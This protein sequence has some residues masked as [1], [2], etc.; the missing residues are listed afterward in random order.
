V[1]RERKN[2]GGVTIP[3]LVDIAPRLSDASIGL[4]GAVLLFVLRG[5]A[6]GGGRRPLLTW[7]EGRR[8][9]WDVLLLFG[10]GLSLAAAMESTGLSVWLGEQMTGLGAL[11]PFAIYLGLAVFVLILSELASNT[12]IATMVMPIVASLGA[13]VDQ[14]PLL[15]M[16]VAALAAS[17]GFALP[18]ATPPNT[19]VFGSGQVSVREM[20]RGGLLLDA[21]AVLVIVAIVSLLYPIVLG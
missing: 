14:P 7:E 15:L 20:A 9:P 8:I 18:I 3:G 4:L 2:F 16:L 11:P 17:T 5:T 12:A 19:I 13:A 10:G 1:L 6:P 21:I